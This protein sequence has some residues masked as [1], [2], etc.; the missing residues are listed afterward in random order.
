MTS[1]ASRTAAGSPTTSLDVTLQAAEGVLLPNHPAAVD[2]LGD[3]VNTNALPFRNT[4]PYVALPNV[5]AV[6]QN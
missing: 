2:G 4:F 3:A 1:P 5:I 6:N